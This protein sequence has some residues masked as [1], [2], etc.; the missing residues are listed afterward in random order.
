MERLRREAENA[1]KELADIK[2][3]ISA[4]G[5]GDVGGKAKGQGGKPAK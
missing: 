2:A 5:G 3:K 1:K 4:T